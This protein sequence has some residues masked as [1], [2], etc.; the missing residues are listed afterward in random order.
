MELVPYAQL[1]TQAEMKVHGFNLT[2]Q[3]ALLRYINLTSV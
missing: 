3:A 2:S 1:L